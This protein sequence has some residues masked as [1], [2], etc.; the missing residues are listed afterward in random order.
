MYN[1]YLLKF[2]FFFECLVSMVIDLHVLKSEVY[3]TF[4]K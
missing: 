2:A 1:F 3:A 4:K